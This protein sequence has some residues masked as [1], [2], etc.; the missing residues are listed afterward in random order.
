MYQHRLQQRL[1][2]IVKSAQAGTQ[3]AIPIFP[4]HEHH[5]VVA[6]HTRI[7]HQHFYVF[8]RMLLHPSLKHGRGLHTVSYIEFQDF[9]VLPFL[10]YQLQR[11]LCLIDPVHTVDQ[12]MVAHT[13][14]SHTD[15]P[16]YSA[17][18]PCH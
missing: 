4:R 9:T 8:F 15:S 12:H 16:P 6:T 1:R 2:H 14:Q 3:H 13:G 17:A 18:A 11:V 7:V 10:T 5:Q